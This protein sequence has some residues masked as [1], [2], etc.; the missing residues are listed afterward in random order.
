MHPES[1]PQALL[2]QAMKE[3]EEHPDYTACHVMLVTEEGKRG[4][5]Q[6]CGV[7]AQDLLWGLMMEITKLQQQMV[8]PK[9][10]VLQ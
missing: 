3:L 10:E 4:W 7:S 5:T 1:Y 8:A 9:M 2:Q 6:S